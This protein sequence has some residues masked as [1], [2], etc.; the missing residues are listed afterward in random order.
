MLAIII[1]YYKL[2]FFEATLA[3]LASQTDQRFKVYIGDDASPE[4]PLIL[5]EKCQDQFDFEYHRFEN[6]LGGV[7][8]VKQWERCIA[9][10][11][12]E[13][14]LMILGDDD[15]L[16]ENV[17]H[18]FYRNLNEI[19]INS[20]VIRF[21]SRKID[22]AGV[23]TTKVYHNPKMERSTD[24]LFRKTRSSLSE[25]MF[26][27][28]QIVTIGFKDFPLAWLS[29]VLAVLEFSDFKEVY[30]INE[31][32]IYIRITDLSISGKQDNLKSKSNATFYFYH[33]LLTHK[34]DYFTLV[35]KKEL[36]QRINKCYL[37]NKR[38]V[39]LFFKISKLYLIN[40]SIKDYFS[41]IQSIYTNLIKSLKFHFTMDKEQPKEPSENI[42]KL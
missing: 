4:D 14:W 22:K 35:Q 3:S 25:Y 40:F 10:S 34:I 7:S 36:L 2:T 6:N 1:P 27:R 24:F 29:D 8:L 28:S 32:V 17:V 19:N 38:E 33:Y 37:N 23:K 21:A 42:N 20:H 31:A 5:L 18:E 26:K 30:S 12:V 16:G 13:E 9:L 41:F 11:G 39:N 15:V